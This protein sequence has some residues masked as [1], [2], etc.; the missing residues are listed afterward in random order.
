GVFTA[1]PQIWQAEGVVGEVVIVI[2]AER[3]DGTGGISN[4][5]VRGM[6]PNGYAFRP[7][8]QI[9]SGRAPKPGTNEVVI[10]RA[11][12]GKF[13]D[14]GGSHKPIEPGS[15]FDVKHNRPLEVVGVFAAGGSYDSEVWGDVDAVRRNAG[16]EGIVSSA[17]LRLRSP[18]DFDAYRQAIEGDARFSMKVQREADYY[19]DQSQQI[20]SF[21]G[22]MF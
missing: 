15:S 12:S 21:L 18:D 22:I 17:R 2:T 19:A 6:T 5:T 13:L 8:L 11:V 4:L 16:R 14:P 9:V 7:E 20:S 10:G 1:Q 3:N